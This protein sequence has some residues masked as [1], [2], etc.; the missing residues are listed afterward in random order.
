MLLP[1][2]P[3]KWDG[4][5]GPPPEAR[6]GPW[7]PPHLAAGHRPPHYHGVGRDHSEQQMSTNTPAQV[8]LKDPQLPGGDRGTPLSPGVS[9]ETSRTEGVVETPRLRES[10]ETVLVS[11]E[12]HSSHQEPGRPQTHEKRPSVNADKD[13]RDVRLSDKDCK[14]VMIKV[15]QHVITNTLET[16]EKKKK[17]NLNKR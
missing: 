6:K 3:A 12:S 11:K 4:S 17:E 10:C 8:G 5:L 14:E 1:P 16:N 7:L 2:M 13:N 9:E 15:L